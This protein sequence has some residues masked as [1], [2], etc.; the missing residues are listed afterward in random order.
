MTKIFFT[1]VALFFSY[2]IFAN[3]KGYRKLL[4]VI[5]G[6]LLLHN[7][8][9]V[10]RFFSIHTW[11]IYSLFFSELVQY[12]KFKNEFREFPFKSIMLIMFIATLIIA[13]PDRR[14]SF[15]NKL[16]YPIREM[17]DTYFIVFLGY[18]AI[19]DETDFT[20]MY[21]P[22]FIGL[23]IV[24]LYGLFNWITLQNPYHEWIVSSY[25]TPGT[26][27]FNSRMSSLYTILNRFRATATFDMPFNYGFVSSLLALFAFTVYFMSQQPSKRFALYGI[28]AGLIGTIICSSRT[29][30]ASMIFAIAIFVSI[31][32]TTKQKIVTFTIVILVSLLAY[33][34]IPS[35]EDSVDNTLDLFSKTGVA[36][37][38]GSDI[39]MRGIQLLGAYQYF[40][41]SPITGNGYGYIEKDLGWGDRDRRNLDKDMFGFESIIYQLMIEQGLL[42]I[43][44][45]MLFLIILCVYFIRRLNTE[46]ILAGFGLSITVLFLFF[47]IGTGPLDAWAISMLF[48]GMTVKTLE[49]KEKSKKDSL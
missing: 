48:I 32:T 26:K 12:K 24:T 35:V 18:F 41:Q 7:T 16:N 39:A 36:K 3:Q 4:W 15:G 9:G 11:I 17:L 45:K 30:L 1:I 13:L 6:I 10:M 8:I 38:K 43:L 47:A 37:A 25:M 21:K 46:M 20:K 29:V 33:N 44:S 23:L 14:L 2:R 42:G 40:L 27:E 19:K 49:M 34:I 31:S 22:I 5:F 28:I